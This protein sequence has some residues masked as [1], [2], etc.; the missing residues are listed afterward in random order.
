M[1]AI[2]NIKRVL[3]PKGFLDQSA[4]MARYVT[5]WRGRHT[6]KTPLVALPKSAAEVSE[7]VKICAGNNIP[8][9]PQGGNTGL[10]QGGVPDA[11]GDQLVINLSRMNRILE[12]NP[13]D[14]AAT[15]EAGVVL[16]GLQA[17]AKQQGLLF[18]LSLAAEG[19]CQIGGNIATNAGGIH[20]MR[21]GPM[22]DL[23]LGLEVVL[24]S[25]EIWDGLKTLLKD[26]TGYDLKQLFIGAEGTLGII[27]RA[28][29][30]LF[31]APRTVETA[32]IGSDSVEDLLAILARLRKRFGDK[33][34][35]YEIFPRSALE[36]V[37]RHIPGTK[38]PFQEPPAW[39]AVTDLWDVTPN[40]SLG[41][42]LEQELA[43]CLDQGLAGDAVAARSLGQAKDFWKLRE[44][45][46]EA[47][48]LDGDGIKHDVSVPLGAIPE[49]IR[50]ADLA[51]EKIIPGFKQ[52]AFGHA[53]DGNIHYDPC[54]PAGMD[55][56]TFLGF[57]SEVNR[58]V[59]DIVADLRGSISAEH[60]IG[61][62]RLLELAHYKSKGDL[63]LSRAIK[64]AF[65]PK[66]LMNPGK[67]IP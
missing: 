45:I 16:A 17:A 37:L 10:V 6:G 26:N 20:V 66:G 19:S 56:K 8:M 41:G 3:G 51:L 30:K 40:P 64:K 14:G 12:I 35:A 52:I 24:P 13:G 61:A 55:Q 49:F 44:T 42:D 47:Q 25:G 28:T 43:G 58:A 27:T 63:A 15:V 22:R 36:M 2:E 33:V 32:I 18:P 31:P 54:P 23:V 62:T 65:D 39:Y 67:L 9:V 5:D 53:G 57:R 38:H 29:L 48:K 11:S 59:H 1:A 34:S 60:G 21:Y 4:D 7:I 46:A 50:R